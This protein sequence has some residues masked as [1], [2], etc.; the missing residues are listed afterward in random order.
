VAVIHFTL[1]LFDLVGL[2]D[3]KQADISGIIDGRFLANCRDDQV[4]SAKT[5][6][7]TTSPIAAKPFDAVVFLVVDFRQSLAP[8]I[9][10]SRPGPSD[11]ALG[12]TYQGSPTGGLAEVYWDKCLNLSEVCTSIFHEAAHLKSGE[13]A[14]M[15]DAAGVRAL[16]KKGAKAV[17]PSWADLEFFTAA[18]KRKI[19]LR[20]TVPS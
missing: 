15:H 12:N 18:I 3:V 8:K 5:S 14:A 6:W 13:G 10:G 9:G 19:T 4:R 16:A 17:H 20:T 1:W 7:A 2:T 11:D